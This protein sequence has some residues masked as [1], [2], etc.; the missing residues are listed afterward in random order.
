MSVGNPSAEATKLVGS[1]PEDGP[2]WQAHLLL[3]QTVRALSQVDPRSLDS[4]AKTWQAEAELD[5]DLESLAE[6]LR[7]LCSL[8]D[9]ADSTRHSVLYMWSM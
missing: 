1:E 6:L 3:P 9:S 8:C 7:E 4:I 5:F 2:E